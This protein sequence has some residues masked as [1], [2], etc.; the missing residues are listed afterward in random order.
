ML[1]LPDII[2]LVPDTK[3]LVVP[4]KVTPQAAEQDRG[5]DAF[6]LSPHSQRLDTWICV[7]FGVGLL[8]G[9]LSFCH[10]C[11]CR[12]MD[13]SVQSHKFFGPWK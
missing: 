8:F 6:V 7:C 9:V 10:H 3:N 5:M 12:L 4:V 2:F 13:L 1:A 11:C